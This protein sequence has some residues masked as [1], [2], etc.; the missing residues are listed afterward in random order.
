MSA[1]LSCLRGYNQRTLNVLLK[2]VE[3]ASD[4]VN[5]FDVLPAMPIR[6]K[7]LLLVYPPHQLKFSSSVLLVARK[8]S[9]LLFFKDENRVD[10]WMTVLVALPRT[11]NG[12]FP[13]SFAEISPIEVEF[14]AYSLPSLRE[15]TELDV[16]GQR[17]KE[18]GLKRVFMEVVLNVGN[19]S[20]NPVKPRIYTRNVNGVSPLSAL[21]R[22]VFPFASVRYPSFPLVS[23]NHKPVLQNPRLILPY[24][25]VKVKSSFF[26]LILASSPREKPSSEGKRAS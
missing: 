13:V 3:T 8:Y 4:V 7:I 1:S 11:H 6:F 20:T 21:N 12:E 23:Q 18:H 5:C 16:V 19:V 15:G 25:V 9:K 10:V 24:N 17:D 2:I 14:Y 26:P 22:D